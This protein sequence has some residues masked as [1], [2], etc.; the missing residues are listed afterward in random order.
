MFSLHRRSEGHRSGLRTRL[1]WLV[2]GHPAQAGG[3]QAFVPPRPLPC[4]STGLLSTAWGSV[5]AGAPLS[6][7]EQ[8]Q[9]S[10][11]EAPVYSQST[12]GTQGSQN[13][14]YP[15]CSRN[16]ELLPR[17]PPSETMH[18]PTG[19]TS[20]G[21]AAGWQAQSFLGML[22]PQTAA[23]YPSRGTDLGALED[24]GGCVLGDGTFRK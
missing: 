2:S 5:A 6:P 24:Q 20:L 11:P 3:M 22:S 9:G 10:R 4:L 7:C 17:M 12:L 1:A 19:S 15:G 16:S 13:R 23:A 18:L 21:D 14:E 8:L